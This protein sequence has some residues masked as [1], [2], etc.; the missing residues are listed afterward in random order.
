MEKYILVGWSKSQKLM[1]HERFHECIFI[2]DI[3]ERIKVY[4]C[5]EDLY[6][7]IFNINNE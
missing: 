4:I 6:K 3:D 2:S 1:E 5:P 7:E